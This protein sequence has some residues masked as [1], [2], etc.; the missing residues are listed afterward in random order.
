MVRRYFIGGFTW[1][2]ES[3][4]DRFIKDGIWENGY[5][6]KYAI[7]SEGWSN[8]TQAQICDRSEAEHKSTASMIPFT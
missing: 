8:N 6:E 3:Q 5:D 1:E 4:K 2:G 7:E